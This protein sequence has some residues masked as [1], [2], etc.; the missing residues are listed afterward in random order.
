MLSRRHLLLG[1]PMLATAAVAATESRTARLSQN[2]PLRIRTITAG[3]ELENASQ[4]DSDLNR[5]L[6]AVLLN[7][8]AAHGA[9]VEWRQEYAYSMQ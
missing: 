9:C 1:M 2:R 3:V 6:R 5:M 4:L 7:F 8:R